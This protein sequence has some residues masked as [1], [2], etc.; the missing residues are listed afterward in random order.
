MMSKDRAAEEKNG[1][2]QPKFPQRDDE[3]R[4]MLLTELLAYALLMLAIGV[5]LLGIVDVLFMVF[6]FGAFGQTSGWIAGTLVAFFFVDD[7]RANKSTRF[8]WPI[9]LASLVLAF[10]AGMA[11]FTQLPLY[12]LPLVNG[13]LGV[14]TAALVH[15]ILLFTGVRI[16]G[17][18]ED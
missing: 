16:I 12:W 14:T 13:A 5:I 4:V 9:L 8:R 17:G 1:D 10:F 3:G 15:G 18:A 6:G 7:F 11:V 2:N